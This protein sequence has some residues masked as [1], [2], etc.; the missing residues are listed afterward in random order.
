MNHNLS[1]FQKWRADRYFR[2]LDK[3]INKSRIVN[4]SFVS[5][6]LIKPRHTQL[7]RCV[8]FPLMEKW[9]RAGYLLYEHTAHDP[10]GTAFVTLYV[11]VKT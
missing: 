2:Y 11:Y 4:D 8:L 5:T 6:I 10:S 3:Q 7:F 1:P 9:G